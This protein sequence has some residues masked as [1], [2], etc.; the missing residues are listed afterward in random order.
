MLTAVLSLACAAA[1]M[2]T[3]RSRAMRR[4]R[5]RGPSLA[6]RVAD[7]IVRAVSRTDSAEDAGS[8]CTAVAAELRCGTPPHRALLVAGGASLVPRARAA[9]AIGEPIAPALARDA[10]A[11]RSAALAA[12]AASWSAA[13]DSGAG[14]ADGL[15]RAA[16]LARAQQRVTAD[17]AT[18][19]AAPRATA[20][21]LAAL[22]VIGVGLGQLLGADPLVW[23]IGSPPGRACL[24]IGLLM[25][26]AGYLWSSRIVARAQPRPMVPRP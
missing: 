12:A 22:P 5:R 18:E 19:T 10:S 8:L 9:A 17:L 15:E 14:L 16:G 25:Q 11:A 3:R 7:R 13:A 2:A 6:G 26:L 4:L 20:R 21:T 1:L 23:L 24:V